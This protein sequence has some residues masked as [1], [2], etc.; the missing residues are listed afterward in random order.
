MLE[1][2]E[3]MHFMTK[4]KISVKLWKYNNIILF[5]KMVTDKYD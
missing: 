2:P 5:P 3:K 4:V 1:A